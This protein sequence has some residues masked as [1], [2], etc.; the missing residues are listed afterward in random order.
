MEPT[1]PIA[2]A[3]AAYVARVAERGRGTAAFPRTRSHQTYG[4]ALHSFELFLSETRPTATTIA[5]LEASDLA[6][7]TRWLARRYQGTTVQLYTTALKGFL[8]FLTRRRALPFDL[9]EALALYEDERPRFRYPTPEVVDGAP[10]V[11]ER[12]TAERP[13][14]AGPTA[15][16]PTRLRELGWL[17]DQALL[18]VLFSTGARIS[19]VLALTRNDVKHGRATLVTVHGKGGKERPLPLPADD[20]A[21][22][23]AYLHA[24][25][26]TS[27]YLFVSHAG[28]TPGAPLSRSYAWKLIT[29]L[30]RDTEAAGLSPHGIRRWLAT[31][32]LRDGEDLK[33]ISAA[34]GH[35]STA[36]TE[37]VYAFVSQEQVAERWGAAAARLRGRGRVRGGEGGEKQDYR[38]RLN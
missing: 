37:Q 24:R 2:E 14:A 11:L 10:A 3:I 26:D 36:V 29:R 8:Q 34:L 13:P 38:Q 6:E 17:R 27:P 23:S 20:R 31:M 35:S 22:I 25:T 5:D 12:H 15:D 16:R 4:Y 33:T 30:A 28:R 18:Q 9:D 19:E 21:A 7:Y 1:T 32:A